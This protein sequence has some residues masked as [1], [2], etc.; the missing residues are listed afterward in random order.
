M[1]ENSTDA[2]DR[3]RF[4]QALGGA[5]LAGLAGCSGDSPG[6]TATDQPGGGDTTTESDDMS[7]SMTE[8]TFAINESTVAL[9]F[10][11]GYDFT[12]NKVTENIWDK[13][14]TYSF[15]PTPK[16]QK[17]LAKTVEQESPTTY[18]YEIKDATFHNGEP[19][20]AEDVKASYARLLNDEV[21]SPIAWALSTLEGGVDGIEVVDEKTVR[22]VNEQEIATWQYMPAFMG[23]A[24]KSA[25]DEHGV[26]FARE[27]GTTVGSGPFKVESWTQGTEIVLTKHEGF[28]RDDIPKLDRLT[29]EIV[30]E[31]STRVSGLKTGELD[32]VGSVPPQQWGQVDDMSNARMETGTTYLEYK[33]SLNNQREPWQTDKE[34]RKAIAYAVDWSEIVENVYF[35]HAVR[36]QGPMPANMKWHND[37]I[38]PYLHDPDQANSLYSESGGI[39]GTVTAITSAG[40]GNRAA[41][42]V[43]Q[44]L[45]DVLGI[46][47]EIEKMPY[48]QRLPRIE[49]GEFDLHFDGWASDYPDPDGHLFAQF[50]S[51]NFPPG[52]N[53]SFFT[54]EEIDSILEQARQTT[55]TADRKQRY[56]EAQEMIHEEAPAIW[57][58]VLDEGFGVNN[59]LSF[60]T[61]TPSW[62]WQAVGARIGP[63]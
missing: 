18:V 36:E 43:Q 13:L 21:G 26:D 27:P 37:D 58:V 40:P 39:D 47:M 8:A 22:I 56:M 12:T 19:I 10:A 34:L 52:N 48:E 3:R 16:L 7:S 15:D 49:N 17:G 41:V 42:I 59:R 45:Q 38:E 35:G 61:I 53:E 54:N 24:P 23:I 63:N 32:V 51:G 57:G 30:P 25:M 14:M 60:P 44:Q 6:E 31:G 46:D 20:T 28:R 50:H 11:M 1:T 4:V 62:F 55:D 2:L 29:F 5:G 9:D 33:F